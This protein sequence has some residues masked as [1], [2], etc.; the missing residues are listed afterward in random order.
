MVTWGCGSSFKL[1][2]NNNC[3]SSGCYIPTFGGYHH[4]YVHECHP[5]LAPLGQAQTSEILRIELQAAKDGVMDGLLLIE[6][7]HVA[8]L[9]KSQ[10]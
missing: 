6:V 1:I 8:K 3:T 2:Y 4:D 7:V 9:R 10:E 5:W